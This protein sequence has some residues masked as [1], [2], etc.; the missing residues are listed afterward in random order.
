MGTMYVADGLTAP[1][2]NVEEFVEPFQQ[3]LM[4]EL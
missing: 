1:L 3:I 2:V 4:K